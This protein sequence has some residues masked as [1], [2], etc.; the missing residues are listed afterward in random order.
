M[1]H[2]MHVSPAFHALPAM[3]I[4]SVRIERDTTCISKIIY[5]TILIVSKD[6]LMHISLVCKYY[7]PE[8][9]WSILVVFHIISDTCTRKKKLKLHITQETIIKGETTEKCWFIKKNRKSQDTNGMLLQTNTYSFC[10]LSKVLTWRLF[11]LT[12]PFWW[13]HVITDHKSTPWYLEFCNR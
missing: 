13:D 9:G 3:R 6:I 1:S 2:A 7:T 12:I 4:Q 11:K 10:F 8:Y 5:K